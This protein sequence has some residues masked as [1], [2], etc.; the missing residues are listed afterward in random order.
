MTDVHRDGPPI[1]I[2]LMAGKFTVTL[3]GTD[4]EVT[5]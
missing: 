4:D 3:V 1:D 5:A 2:D